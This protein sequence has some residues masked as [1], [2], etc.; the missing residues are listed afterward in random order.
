MK[1]VMVKTTEGNRV[2]IADL[3]RYAPALR[4]CQVV[5]MGRLAATDEAGLGCHE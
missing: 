4:E 3:Q 5:G 1:F 2:L